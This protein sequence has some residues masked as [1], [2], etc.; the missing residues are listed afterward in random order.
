MS[1]GPTET[2]GKALRVQGKG[3]WVR[4]GRVEDQ[5]ETRGPRKGAGE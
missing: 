4:E 5:R 2:P 1:G 3:L